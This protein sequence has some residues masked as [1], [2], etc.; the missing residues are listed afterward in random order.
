MLA[1]FGGGSVVINSS[2]SATV[3]VDPAFYLA[4]TLR[5]VSVAQ[6]KA[7]ARLFARRGVRVNALL[8]GY[9]DTALTRRAAQRVADDSKQPAESV[10]RSWEEGIPI[11]RLAAADE[12]AQ[13]A[14]FLLSSASSYVTGSAIQVDGGL[15]T[16]HYNF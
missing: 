9:V 6:A 2:C 4:N 1:T 5:C 15:S 8:T 11:G 13:V 3:P 16:A 14:G 12:I 7:Y 10:W